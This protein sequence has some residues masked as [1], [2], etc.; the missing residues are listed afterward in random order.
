MLQIFISFRKADGLSLPTIENV[1][2]AREL[3]QLLLS[4]H[5]SLELRHA[6]LINEKD[7]NE[8]SRSSKSL[9]M[10]KLDA[11]STLACQVIAAF[12]REDD[13]MEYIFGSGTK[14]NSSNYGR[15]KNIIGYLFV[16]SS[17][18]ICSSNHI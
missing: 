2:L 3:R 14:T 16:N 18:L 5:K 13:Q 10:D 8:S 4:Y 1:K 17:R 6:A 9:N 7:T 15:Y 11:S 12:Q